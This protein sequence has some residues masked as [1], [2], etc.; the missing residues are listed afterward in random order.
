[1]G[2]DDSIA[3][4]VELLTRT[5]S[6]LDSMIGECNDFLKECE[7]AFKSIQDNI[8]NAGNTA[9]VCKRMIAFLNEYLDRRVSKC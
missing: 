7:K 6:E 4:Y 2:A 3:E 9:A 5:V 8:L 1:M